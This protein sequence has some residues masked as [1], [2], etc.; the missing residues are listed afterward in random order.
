MKRSEFSPGDEQR[1][2]SRI[3]Q[4]F[5][6]TGTVQGVGFRPFV[7]SLAIRY[8]LAGFVKNQSGGV[9][10]E[11]EGDTLTLERFA[12]SLQN[13]APSL[14]RI[15]SLTI[16]NLRIEN[17][18]VEGAHPENKSAFH[19]LPS[20]RSAGTSTSLVPDI[21][22]CNECLRELDDPDDRRFGY[23]FINCTNCGPRYTIVDAMPYDRSRTT[24]N[25]FTMCAACDREFHDPFDRRFHSQA[26]ACPD[27]GPTVWWVLGARQTTM[28]ARRSAFKQPTGLVGQSA[29]RAFHQAISDDA[30]V[31]VK[32]VG[33]FHLACAAD[34][35]TAMMRLRERKSRPH[36]PLAVMI[37]NLQQAERIAY[38]DADSRRLLESRERPIVLLRKRVG[39]GYLDLV[40]PGVETIGLML[41]YSPLH[42]LLVGPR[43]LI[44]TSGNISDAP[45]VRTNLDACDRLSP[46]ADAFLLHDREIQAACDD[47]IVRLAGSRKLPLRRARGYAPAPIRIPYAGPSILAVGSDL[48]ASFCMT[49]DGLAYMSPHIGDMGNIESFHAFTK[50][51]EHYQRL[52]RIE[53]KVVACDKHPG[54]L[55]SQWARQYADDQQL[56]LV[57]VQ[58]HHAHVAAVHAEHGLDPKQRTIGVSF[59][60]TG[61]G[62]DGT[63]WGGE[64]LV[65]SCLESN[66]WA[67]LS[68]VL[69]PGGDASIKHPHR[70]ALAYLHAAG[71]P[72]DER[73]PCVAHCTQ[74][75]LEI[76]RRQLDRH[77]NCTHTTSMGRLFDAVA[78]LI[79]VRQSISYEAQAAI[80]METMSHEWRCQNSHDVVGP[81]N[82][83]DLDPYS[84]EL[85]GNGPFVIG[86]AML[87]EEVIRDTLAGVPASAIARRFLCSITEAVV[88]LC[89]RARNVQGIGDVVLTGGVFQNALL[90]TQTIAR[91]EEQE[92]RVMTHQIVPPN[93][94]GL[95]LG[96]AAVAAACHSD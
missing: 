65:A 55:S 43:P 9:T 38:M 94:G 16:E 93:D 36:K 14:A 18:D 27:C 50:A 76:L 68:E 34:S 57:E 85:V 22:T 12:C 2:A 59:D 61:Y 35:S 49:R 24:M 37:A 72:W 5:L 23:P 19:V 25:A 89:E 58:H 52:F 74:R 84:I 53:P 21:A 96:Q 3:R 51:V 42:Y 15:D 7:H 95:A 28:A 81:P 47:S 54:Y 32:G 29:I 31:A 71:L 33:G 78:S 44:L 82:A 64:I 48:K 4:R 40:A 90:L 1:T 86:T 8:Q 83:V 87:L 63:I 26:N 67:H 75:D 20:D 88:Q 79:G 66:R 80:E 60:G 45:I 39:S 41:P 73:L 17:V 6:I 10:I 13:E 77:L 46:L 69:L 70:T 30:I 62:N 92:F 56:G 91:L 11:A